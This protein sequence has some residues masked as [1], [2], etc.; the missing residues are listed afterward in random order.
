MSGKKLLFVAI[1]II[2]VGISALSGAFAGG[3]AVYSAVRDQIPEAVNLETVPVPVIETTNQVIN[4]QVDTAIT[5]AVEKIGPAVVTV[6]GII[7]GQTTIFGPTQD[8][9]V[10]GS[11]VII[12]Q[13]G[14]ILT[15]NHVVEDTLE[16]SII[17]ADGDE[18]PVEIVGRDVFSD[19]AVLKMEGVVPAVASLGNSDALKPGE[20]VIAI[21]SPLGDFKNTVTAGVVSATE[22]MLDVN[23]NY[24]M[25]GLIQTDA[26][27]NQ[28]NSGGPLVNLAGQVIGINTL[29]V[30]G[31]T[32]SS[33]VA[34][35]LGFAIPANKAQ[36]VAAQLIEKGYF[37]YPYL[38]IRW[39]WL[40]PQITQRYDLPVEGGVYISSVDSG[41]PADQAGLQEGDIIT[42]MGNQTLDEE[43]P[44]INVLYN[45]T[46]GEITALQIVRGETPLEISVKFGEYLQD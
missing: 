6:V 17:L 14:Y 13:D 7:P 25:E 22:R 24:Q 9:P 3:L 1:L 29:I 42:Q 23:Q 33:A 12:S 16:V 35:G 31:N 30:R 18:Y 44:F 45:Y 40:T 26:A 32:Y 28:G 2:A 38:G 36:A 34:E 43:H 20:T 15:N 37:S 11:G 41:S 5:Q 46:P 21:G 27:I 10:S 4:I 39:Q 19:L 8:S